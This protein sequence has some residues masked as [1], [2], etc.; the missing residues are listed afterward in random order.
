MLSVECFPISLPSIT[1]ALVNS[2]GI[3]QSGFAHVAANHDYACPVTVLEAIKKTAEFFENKGVDSPRLQA[4]LLL[5]H[6]LKLPRMKLYLN[7]ERALTSGEVDAFREMVRRRGLRE[8]LQ[9][10][11][12]TVSFCGLELIT[13]RHA[14]IPRP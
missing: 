10:I 5:A 9:H 4:E 6:V 8:P 14:L 3:G 7:F 2:F 1:S 11:V 12:G 13:N